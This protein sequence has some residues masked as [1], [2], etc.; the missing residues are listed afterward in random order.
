MQAEA[1]ASAKPEFAR[2]LERYCLTVADIERED[3][4]VPCR[5]IALLSASPRHASYRRPK[6]LQTNNLDQLKQ[7]IGVP[8]AA[9]KG[10][11]L[12]DRDQRA[13]FAAIQKEFKAARKEA[14]AAVRPAGGVRLDALRAYARS[15]LFGD[16]SMV[17][18]AKPHLEAFFDVFAVAVWAFPKVKVSAGSV[19]AFGPGANVLLASELEIEEGGQIVSVGSLTVRIAGALRKTVPHIALPPVS[20]IHALALLRA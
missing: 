18:A 16:S 6:I 2:I 19:L 3:L 13:D 20:L 1:G 7:W 5:A 9:V 8:D 17:A 4:I 14:A 12:I 11:C 15:Y 10:R